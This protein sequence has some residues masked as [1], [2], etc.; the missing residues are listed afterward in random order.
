MLE[1]LPEPE[2]LFSEGLEPAGGLTSGSKSVAL[3]EANG[4]LGGVLCDPVRTLLEE[5]IFRSTV[6][7]GL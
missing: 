5:S 3:Q 6:P 2:N 4:T 1:A 7:P